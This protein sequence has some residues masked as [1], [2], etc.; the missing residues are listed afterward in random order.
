MNVF[1]TCRIDLNEDKT[2]NS[3]DQVTI[4]RSDSELAHVAST[5]TAISDAVL[6]SLKVANLNFLSVSV[7]TRWKERGNE[8]AT[9]WEAE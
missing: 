5:I 3:I 6:E 2:R 4:H 8:R 1:K 7:V 9:I